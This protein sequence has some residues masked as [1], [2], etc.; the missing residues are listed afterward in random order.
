MLYSEKPENSLTAS[1]W[2]FGDRV[3][4]I[5]KYLFQHGMARIPDWISKHK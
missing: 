2:K 5:A 3:R 1:P 4:E